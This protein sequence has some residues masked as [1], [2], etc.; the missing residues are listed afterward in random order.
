MYNPGSMG[1]T[2]L[3][4]E[5]PFL[6]RTFFSTILR[7]PTLT[8]WFDPAIQAH[9]KEESAKYLRLVTE[10]PEYAKAKAVGVPG[11][12]GGAPYYLPWAEL[13][14]THGAAN[15]PEKWKELWVDSARLLGY[16]GEKALEV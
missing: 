6:E 12:V 9:T 10:E 2:A 5:R 1:G 3:L 8:N 14:A 13:D 7:S 15:E 16:S 4:R 11:E